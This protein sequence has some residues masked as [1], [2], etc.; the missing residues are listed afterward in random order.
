M[1][2][3]RGNIMQTLKKLSL[4]WE[5]VS[6]RYPKERPTLPEAYQQIYNEH[7]SNNRNGK[8]KVTFFSSKVEG[9][10]HR[11]VAQ[12]TIEQDDLVTLEIGAGTLNQLKF[13]KTKC[14]DIVE[15]LRMLYEQA[16]QYSR[17][18]NA[19]ADISEVVRGEGVYD[20]ITAIAA[21]EHICNLTE[22][23]EQCTYLLKPGG[24]LRVAIP[25]EGRFLWKVAYEM[26]TGLEFRHRYHLAYSTMMHYEHVNTADEIET[27]L[28]HYFPAVKMSLA[29][30]T[31]DLA[32]F[33]Y[34]EC[35]NNK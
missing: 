35:T 24:C 29:G 26:T 1:K 14:Y 4:S 7:Y 8:T 19:Y 20:R 21:F 28:M 13:E 25:N 3:E 22:V 16:D 17:I 34:Y 30:I 32:L 9:W 11:K 2:L 27:I 31:R 33:R 23:V 18:R 15:P 6:A 12:D 10:M 5:E